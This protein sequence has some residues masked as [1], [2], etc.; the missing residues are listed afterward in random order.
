MP[1]SSGIMRIDNIEYSDGPDRHRGG[2]QC[3][4]QHDGV[5]EGHDSTCC[6]CDPCRHIRPHN[7]R[8]QNSCCRC[9]PRIICMKFIPDDVSNACCRPIGLPLFPTFARG[10]RP[11][12]VFNPAT[13]QMEIVMVEVYWDEQV[14]Y[15]GTISGITATLMIH[16]PFENGPCF[17]RVT[18]SSGY[19]SVDDQIEIDHV[20][21]TC[22]SV[23]AVAISGVTDAHGC[24]GTIT[25]SNYDAVKLPFHHNLP[26]TSE[27]EMVTPINPQC[28]CLSVPKFLCVDGIRHAGEE[29]EQVVF[30][31]NEALGDRWEY[32]P[33]IPP[34]VNGT[35]D[36]L[37][38]RERIYLRGDSYGN[39][40]L[41]FDFEQTGPWTNDWASPQNT[42]GDDIHEIR[43][44]MVPIE[45]CGCNIHAH[46]FTPDNTRF[47]NISATALNECGCWKYACSKCRCV[48]TRICLIGEID[49][50]V[51]S[52]EAVWNGNGWA[53]G[54]ILI[55]LGKDKCGDCVLFASGT[56]SVP[57]EP[58]SP[59][60]CGEF[61]AGEVFSKYDPYQPQVF[62]QLWISASV[63]SC[64]IS[65]CGICAEER[66]GGPPEVIYYEIETYSIG[67]DGQPF[68]YETCNI[69]IALNYFQRFYASGGQEHSIICGYVGYKVVHCPA[70]LQSDGSV[71]RAA[72]TF[73]IRV[74]IS[75]FGGNFTYAVDRAEL[76]SSQL[77]FNIVWPNRPFPPAGS[78]VSCDPFVIDSGWINPET[79]CRWGCSDLPFKMRQ[80]F[81][82]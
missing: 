21:V 50:V 6:C 43:D 30:T 2:N 61:L 9:V 76:N 37:L 16:R 42:L 36:T 17:W 22:L 12:Q 52:G 65:P 46:S 49:G 69:T 79:S 67:V 47:V 70:I 38:L 13:G 18:S 27:P 58:S 74:T 20:N 1:V 10:R 45:S 53:L 31:W 39:C 29:R 32:C 33:C 26:S 62:N 14:V 56:F 72:E 25:F 40:Y 24:V 64:I 5:R 77:V 3:D 82:E 23:P 68:G 57:F 78:T 7:S 73:V 35:C 75:Y 34:G 4:A 63:C 80:T 48:P 44:G 28:D 60:A 19:V 55:S 59:I 66:C 15:T 11:I 51:V 41:E 71:A 81:V 54:G 8:V